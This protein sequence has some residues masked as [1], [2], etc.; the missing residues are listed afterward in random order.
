MESRDCSGIGFCKM[1]IAW[2]DI[3]SR[4]EISADD[5]ND[6]FNNVYILFQIPK[7]LYQTRPI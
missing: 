5:G 4:W 1:R 6:G 7:H 3:Q 2:N